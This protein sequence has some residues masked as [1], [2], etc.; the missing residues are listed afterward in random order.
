MLIVSLGDVSGE[1]IELAVKKLK[2]LIQND[3]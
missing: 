3:V 1:D 2:F